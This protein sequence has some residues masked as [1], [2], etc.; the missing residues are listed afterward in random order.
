MRFPVRLK[1]I[2]AALALAAALPT[3]AQAATL[4]QMAGQMVLVGFKG[5]SV[6][7]ATVKTL[8]DEIRQGQIGGLMYLRA[9]VKSLADV[10]AMNAAFLAANPKLPVFI[11]L[12]QE[13]GKIERLTGKVGF[14]EMPS[15]QDI[16]KDDTPAEAQAIY[17]RTGKALRASGFNL[18]F[19]PV[20]DLNINPD[21]PI[22]G[23]YGRSF[24]VDPDRVTALAAAAIAAYHGAGVL[25]ALKHFPGHGSSTTDSHKGFVDVTNTWKPVELDPYRALIKAGDVDLVMVGHLYNANYPIPGDK[26]ELPASLSPVW[27]GKILRTQL[28]YQGVVI[29]DDLEMGAIRDLFKGDGKAGILRQTVV[30]A[31]NAGTN[32]LLFSNTADY[33]PDLGAEVQA[34]LVDE[35][36]KDPA[37]AKKIKASYDLITALKAKLR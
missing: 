21:N 1:S 25:T 16:G 26:L 4:A 11:S 23:H 31:V 6:D 20:V 32:I 13:G 35:G 33:D 30:R 2:L 36:K 37:F 18:N 34:V 22:I 29:S 14:P 8:I 24:G 7:D 12:D 17:A 5:T 27:I 9:N 28:G 15:E 10:R 19:A 3:A